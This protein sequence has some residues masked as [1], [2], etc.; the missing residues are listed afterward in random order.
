MLNI[1]NVQKTKLGFKEWWANSQNH[2]LIAS[3]NYL[4]SDIQYAA[5]AAWNVAQHVALQDG[6]QQVRQEINA[7]LL[8]AL[9]YLLAVAPT[10]APSSDDNLLTGAEARYAYAV[11]RAR[12]VIAEIK[13]QA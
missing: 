12:A 2:F 11:E 13:E 6:R 3:Q 7:D 10:P 9:K 5:Q 4:D 1:V 8:A